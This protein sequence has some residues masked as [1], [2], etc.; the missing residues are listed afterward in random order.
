MIFI[1]R[2]Y[3]LRLSQVALSGLTLLTE[4]R[5]HFSERINH[6]NQKIQIR[7]PCFDKAALIVSHESFSVSRLLRDASHSLA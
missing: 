7:Y 2:K 6:V 3:S 4:E 1:T 5:L